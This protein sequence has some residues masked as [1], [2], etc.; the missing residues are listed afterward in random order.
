MRIGDLS[1]AVHAHVVECAPFRLLLGRPLNALK[2][3]QDNSGG[4]V[5][6]GH[7]GIGMHYYRIIPILYTHNIQVNQHFS[8]Y[9]LLHLLSER[10]PVALQCDTVFFVFH[11]LPGDASWY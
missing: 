5:V 9:A 10:Q 8:Y 4:I 1:F 11:Q 3:C 7:P 6:T 2:G